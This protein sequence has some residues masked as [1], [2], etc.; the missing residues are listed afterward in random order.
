MLQLQLSHLKGLSLTTAKFKP[1]IFSMSGFVLSYPANMFILMILH[2]FCLLPAQF[3]YAVV[4]IQRV[5]SR[6][7]ITDRRSPC[8]I[9]NSAE[10]L[11][12]QALQFQE[13]DVWSKFPGGA[14]TSH[15]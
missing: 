1:L 11:V 13:V 3:Y 6:V 9:S 10:N 14:S 12:L 5:E 8:K 4:Y 2:D 15:Y 7:Q